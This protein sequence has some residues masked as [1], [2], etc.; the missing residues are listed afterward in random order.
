METASADTTHLTPLGPAL[1]LP[2]FLHTDGPGAPRWSTHHVST[3]H[4]TMILTSYCCPTAPEDRGLSGARL[5][6][7]GPV[8]QLPFLDPRKCHPPNFSVSGG[9]VGDK[10]PTT[11]AKPGYEK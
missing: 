11:Y 2:P 3:W 1:R 8:T 6:P 9:I 7:G 5:A 10:L 4:G